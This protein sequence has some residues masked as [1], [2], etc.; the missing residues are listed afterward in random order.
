MKDGQVFAG[1]NPSLSAKF[2]P[3]DEN[4]AGDFVFAKQA[5]ETGGFFNEHGKNFGLSQGWSR[6]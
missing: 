1:S 5:G 6:H 2:P 3:Q 4:P